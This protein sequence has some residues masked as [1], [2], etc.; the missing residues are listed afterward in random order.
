M[1]RNKVYRSSPPSISSAA[2]YLFLDEQS[3]DVPRDGETLGEV[4]QVVARHPAVV[5]CAD[6]GSALPTVGS[7]ALGAQPEC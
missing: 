7:L 3:R 1:S 5:E 4:E 2:R 6:R